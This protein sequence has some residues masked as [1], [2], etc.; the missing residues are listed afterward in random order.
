MCSV[1]ARIWIMFPTL[2]ILADVTVVHPSSPSRKSLI[3]LSAA[4]V[5]EAKKTSTYSTLANQGVKFLAFAVETFGGF[6]KEAS[7]LVDFL[8]MGTGMLVQ[9]A[10]TAFFI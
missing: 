3:E 2:R 6:G 7:A 9:A 1:C 5:A 4:T 10:S 8:R